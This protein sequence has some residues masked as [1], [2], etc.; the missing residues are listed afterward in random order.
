MK[1]TQGTVL[2]LPTDSDFTEVAVEEADRII[3]KHAKDND[4]KLFGAKYLSLGIGCDLLRVID[5]S[6]CYGLSPSFD[7]DYD[8]DEWSL[9]ALDEKDFTH[10]YCW[11]PGA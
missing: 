4:I 11:T 5:V 9:L 1:P 10:I 8:E 3:R 6:R 7:K 2:R